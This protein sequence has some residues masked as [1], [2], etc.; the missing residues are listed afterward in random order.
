M[1]Y[2]G[3]TF[4][5]LRAQTLPFANW[6]LLVVDNKSTPPLQDRLDVGWHPNATLVREEQLGLAR[7]RIT[8]FKVA[9]GD[10]VVLVDD[11]NVLAADYLERALEIAQKFPFIGTWSGHIELALEKD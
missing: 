11:D 1:D 3:R 8:G 10:L 7:T 4:D 5:A 6:E 2:L 9:K